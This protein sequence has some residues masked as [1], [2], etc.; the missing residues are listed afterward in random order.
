MVAAPLPRA[1]SAQTRLLLP[2]LF[3]RRA[4]DRAA[5]ALESASAGI[6]R[7]PGSG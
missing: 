2:F 3:E 1:V 5:L 6:A 4:A 7:G